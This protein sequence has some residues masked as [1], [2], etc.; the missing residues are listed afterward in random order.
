M[1]LTASRTDLAAPRPSRAARVGALVVPGA[2]LLLGS[3]VALS[4]LEAHAEIVHA[5]EALLLL[6]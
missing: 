6:R 1:T 4:L 5:I 2:L 3:T